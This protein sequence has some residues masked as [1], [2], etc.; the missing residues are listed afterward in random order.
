MKI[1]DKNEESLD[2]VM[3]L[4]MDLSGLNTSPSIMKI[5]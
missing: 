4:S 5:L 1:F 3:D 2:S